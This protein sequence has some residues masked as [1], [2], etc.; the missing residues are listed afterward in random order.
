MTYI[1][2]NL[3]VSEYIRQRESL[4]AR[5]LAE[6]IG[7]Q[8]LYEDTS[9]LFKPITETQVSTAKAFEDSLAK[10]VKN[11]KAVLEKNTRSISR[12]A[13]NV[14]EAKA[15][16]T[17]D[18]H[19]Q[20]RVEKEGHSQPPSLYS[21]D[22]EYVVAPKYNFPDDANLEITDIE[23]LKNLGLDFPSEVIKK[24]NIEEVLERIQS[25]NRAIGQILGNTAAGK[26]ATAIEKEI[27]ESRKQTLK[28]YKQELESAYIS[29]SRKGKGLGSVAIHYNKPIELCESLQLLHAAKQAGNNGEDN[30][31]N[32]I[33][34]ELLRIN[35]IGKVTYNQLYKCIFHPERVVSRKNRARHMKTNKQK[36]EVKF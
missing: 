32:A 20:R 14:K 21:D 26:K 27:A 30:N 3:N 28:K 1:P 35:Q 25:E 24:G 2:I 4:R 16:S 33:L 31:I 23:N 8:T 29:K 18:L 7:D 13:Q 34:D 12:L 36:S 19:E 6:K 22:E 11:T 5:D 10:S 9:K 17:E 15:A